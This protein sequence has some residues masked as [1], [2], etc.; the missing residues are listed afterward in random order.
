[1]TTKQGGLSGRTT[2]LYVNGEAVL[3]H[4]TGPRQQQLVAELNM[5]PKGD[6]SPTWNLA[7]GRDVMGE[8]RRYQKSE[9]WRE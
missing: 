9:K 7:W 8:I 3:P 2:L 6:T 1:M 4:H 5:S